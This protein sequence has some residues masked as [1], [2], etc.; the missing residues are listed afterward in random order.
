[1]RLAGAP[2]VVV[3]M[4]LLAGCSGTDVPPSAAAGGPAQAG[5]AAPRTSAPASVS[6]L[7]TDPVESPSATE[8]SSGSPSPSATELSSGS[9]S[10]ATA[11]A[12]P[13]PSASTTDEQPPSEGRPVR[14]TL[15]GT[16]VG[17]IAAGDKPA[18]PQAGAIRLWDAGVAWRQLER[19]PGRVDW[20]AMDR[21]VAR[22][23]ATGARDILWV[24]G[25]PPRWAARRP[26]SSGLYGPGTSSPPKTDAY[27]SILTRVAQRYR[28]RITSYQVWN[29]ANISIFY[30]GSAS[31]LADL[32]QKARRVLAEVDPG[33]R[34]VGASTT[35]RSQGPV[36]KWY[37]KYAS[38]L[39]ARGWPVDAMAVHLYPRAD[40]GPDERAGYIRFMRS[41]L[42][43]RGWTGQL[44]DTE[45][46]YGDRRDF[47]KEEVVIGQRTAEAWVGRTYLDSLALGIDRVY[48]YAWNDHILGIDQISLRTG[49]ILP[50]GRAYLTIQQWLSGATWWGCSGELM[51]PTGR[52]GAVTTCEFTDAEGTRS[53][54]LFTHRGTAKVGRPAG[55]DRV[56]TLDGSCAPAKGTTLKVG[57]TPL[58]VR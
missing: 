49:Q 2:V 28:G 44:W 51:Q 46:N 3:A 36:K 41:W 27:L 38:A 58:L 15:F 35:V 31:Y 5:S 30:Q 50:A 39:A 18:P 26:N 54:V 43:E 9:S 11:P 32:T 24:H 12:G 6:Q 14:R 53:Y 45:I 4:A 57:R 40:E 42:A 34:L 48:W 7:S 21:A 37:G 22:A 17:G 13:N 52:K 19:S 25:S 10:S 55:T 20:A 33:A 29:E 47:A 56:C 23:E 8:L 16:H 1:M